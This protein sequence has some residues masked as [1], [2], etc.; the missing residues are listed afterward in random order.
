MDELNRLHSLR[1]SFSAASK[2]IF[3]TETYVTEVFEIYNS[4]RLLH[5]WIDVSLK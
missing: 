4:S 5:R 1:G 3:A 2:P